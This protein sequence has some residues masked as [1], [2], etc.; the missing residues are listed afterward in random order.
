[1]KVTITSTLE[2]DRVV[3][4]KDL[5]VVDWDGTG[6]RLF[7][8]E[9]DRDGKLTGRERVIAEKRNDVWTDTTGGRIDAEAAAVLDDLEMEHHR[10]RDGSKPMPP[11]TYWD[12]KLGHYVEPTDD[13]WSQSKY[14]RFLRDRKQ[15]GHQTQE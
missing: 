10:V 2:R 15:R 4:T 3:D 13:E 7:L 14:N 12:E 5:R 1:M 9:R 8:K 6:Y 11:K